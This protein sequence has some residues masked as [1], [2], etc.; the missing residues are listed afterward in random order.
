MTVNLSTKEKIEMRGFVLGEWESGLEPRA[1][2][3][4]FGCEVVR[5]QA[6]VPV[7]LGRDTICV[8]V[9]YFIG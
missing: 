1:V 5:A 6:G 3:R 2:V 8:L 4:E 7:P 9:R